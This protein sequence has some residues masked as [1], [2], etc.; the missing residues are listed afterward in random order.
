MYEGETIA[1]PLPLKRKISN[2]AYSLFWRNFLY[3]VQCK[4][5]YRL[6]TL[7]LV[8]QISPKW[9]FCFSS[10]VTDERKHAW[11]DTTI[12]LMLHYDVIRWNIFRVT[13]P[14]WGKST[15]NRWIP[16]TKAGEAELWCL[17]WSA[18]EQRRR[19]WLRRHRTH[20]DVTVMLPNSCRPSD[21]DNLPRKFVADVGWFKAT[22][23]AHGR[24]RAC[25]SFEHTAQSS[26]TNH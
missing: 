1:H 16:L 12:V 15:G 5:S 14:L 17:L 22:A 23:A 10:Y 26:V 2:R 19:R 18:P 21:P 25:E 11:R 4:L 7:H 24:V 8:T 6:I 3:W 13:G 9:H 20:Y